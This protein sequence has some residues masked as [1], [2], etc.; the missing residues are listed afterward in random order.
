MRMSVTTPATFE[1]E[2][3]PPT[4][5]TAILF[6]LFLR[7]FRSFG[8]TADKMFSM[9]RM[10]VLRSGVHFVARAP[11][12]FEAAAGFFAVAAMAAA[13]GRFILTGPGELKTPGRKKTA[14]L[15]KTLLSQRAESE[16][17]LQAWKA[18]TLLSKDGYTVFNQP[19]EDDY[20][21]FK[22]AVPHPQT[23]LWMSK[24]IT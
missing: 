22:Q 13:A 14:C 23:L 5:K 17:Y 8:G 16:N 21:I 10:V 9:A 3:P 2:Q 20:T 12:S 19:C 15:C 11:R 7:V 24:M 4:G 18:A 6:K 1:P